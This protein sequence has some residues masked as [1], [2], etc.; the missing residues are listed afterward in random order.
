MEI[1]PLLQR[2][3]AMSMMSSGSIDSTT[4]SNSIPVTSISTDASPN[5]SPRETV[6][7]LVENA[8]SPLDH[9]P[10][11]PTAPYPPRNISPDKVPFKVGDMDPSTK[12]RTFSVGSERRSPKLIEHRFPS[13]GAELCESPIIH[14][15]AGNIPHQTQPQSKKKPQQEDFEQLELIGKGVVSGQVMLVRSKQT[16]EVYQM[17]VIEKSVIKD[18]IKA[19]TTVKERSVLPR[20]NHPFLAKVCSYQAQPLIILQLKFSFQNKQQLFFVEDYAKGGNLASHLTRETCFTIDRCRFYGAQIACGLRYL[21]A[22]NITYRTLRTSNVLL[23]EEGNIIMTNFCLSKEGSYI[24]IPQTYKLGADKATPN[25]YTFDGKAQK[26]Y[27]SP[28]FIQGL[29]YSNATDYWSLGIILHEMATGLEENMARLMV[30]RILSIQST[31]RR[32]SASVV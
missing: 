12:A 30:F 31:I 8:G 3:A 14:P 13:P 29:E 7:K 24:H 25:P 23:T 22:N 5:T 19:H 1:L 15:V 16:H 28:E 21:H 20:L 6:G 10:P 9:S 11:R 4:T 27:L 2:L 17:K 32:E 18:N 26:Q